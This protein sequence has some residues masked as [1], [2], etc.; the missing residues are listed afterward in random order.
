MLLKYMKVD[1]IVIIYRS[2]RKVGFIGILQPFRNA[3]KLFRSEPKFHHVIIF[4]GE[5]KS[6]NALKTTYTNI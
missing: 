5:G 6:I 1:L 4:D 2:P 3:I